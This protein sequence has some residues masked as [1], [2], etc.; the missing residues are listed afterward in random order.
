[1]FSLFIGND[2]SEQRVVENNTKINYNNSVIHST[3]GIYEL[4]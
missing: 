2:V 1:M 4:K 3:I